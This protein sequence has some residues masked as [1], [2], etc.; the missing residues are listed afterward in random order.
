MHHTILNLFVFVIE[1]YV[2]HS[3]AVIR[4]HPFFLQI[5]WFDCMP[6]K[7]FV[8]HE[9]DCLNKHFDYSCF[10]VIFI[11]A[12]P[13]TYSDILKLACQFDKLRKNIYI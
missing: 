8:Y 9:K 10:F 6:N 4:K 3:K 5:S 12:R 11:E 13:R 1:L 7:Y 2:R